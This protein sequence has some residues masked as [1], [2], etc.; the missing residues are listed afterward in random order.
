MILCGWRLKSCIHLPELQ[1][2]T[3]DDRPADVEISL[4]HIVEPVD[5]PVFV[6]PHSRLWGNGVYFFSVD[7]VGRFLMEGGRRVVIEP[8]AGA[9]ESDL[10]L[11]LLG[12]I[13]G[14]LCHQRGLLPIHASAVNID[15]RAVV[16]AGDSG[17]GKST[18]AAALGQRG[19]PLVADDIVAI[20]RQSMALPAFPQRKLAIDV[21]EVLA[22]EYTELL[23]NRPCQPKYRVPALA[24]FDPSP[25]KPLVI[26]ILGDQQSEQTVEMRRQGAAASVALIDK[27]IYR[28]GV[29]MRIQPKA[30][31]LGSIARLVQNVPVY[32]LPSENGK[33]LVGLGRLAERV[34]SHVLGM[35]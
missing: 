5:A 11:F 23:P 34:E 27:M 7:G 21:L 29:G 19:H 15:G 25:L 2:W 24:D 33:P 35:L 3:G 31:M 30:A 12:T 26:Y 32:R 20:N 28:R 8:A 6:R 17:A 10:R 22:L 16:F 18:I 14:V 13:L 1:A 4:G 9:A